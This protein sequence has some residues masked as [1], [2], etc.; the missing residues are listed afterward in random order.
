MRPLGRLKIQSA[1]GTSL[2]SRTVQKTCWRRVKSANHAPESLDESNL[3]S[4]RCEPVHILRQN[5]GD[6]TFSRRSS[7]GGR[8]EA[9]KLALSSESFKMLHSM[10]VA[11][12]MILTPEQMRSK[13]RLRRTGNE[14]GLRGTQMWGKE[15]FRSFSPS[16]GCRCS[17]LSWPS[18]PLAFFNTLSSIL[19]SLQKQRSPC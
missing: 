14:Q 13:S 19:G 2:P 15:Q 6:E 16:C 7:R 9:S 3:S 17:L 10:V 8:N 11:E 12:S 4:V 18:F 5:E 1:L